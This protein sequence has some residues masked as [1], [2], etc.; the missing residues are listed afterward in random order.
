MKFCIAYN[1]RRSGII[2]MRLVIADSYLTALH[3][4]FEAATNSKFEED[5]AYFEDLLIAARRLGYNISAIK[6]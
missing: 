2:H 3:M 6:V 1:Y 4:A 5:D